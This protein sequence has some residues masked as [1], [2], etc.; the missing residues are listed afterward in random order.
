MTP[1]NRMPFHAPPSHTDA[2][3]NTPTYIKK[4]LYGIGMGIHI[5]QTFISCITKAMEG[6]GLKLYVAAAYGRLNGIFNSKSWVKAL[7]SYHNVASSHLKR[8][9]STGPNTFEPIDEYLDTAWAHS[10]GPHWVYNFLLPTL[11]IHQFEHAEW[12]GN[13]YFK[14]FMMECTIK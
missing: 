11:L 1:W 4:S 3:L 9:P 5:I 7:R 14:H 2:I 8:F 6:S 12:E 10:T 13:Y